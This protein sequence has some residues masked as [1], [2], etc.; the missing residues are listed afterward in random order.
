MGNNDENGPPSSV[1]SSSHGKKVYTDYS[2]IGIPG[3]GSCLFRSVV[4]GACLVS[5]K[6]SPSE[7]LEK[8]LADE[9]R[10]R[11]ADEFIQRREETE[12]LVALSVS[13]V[14]AFFVVVD[15]WA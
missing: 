11:V 6:P 10:A 8:Q 2:I 14:C 12:W 7:A 5:G 4:H 9:L 1:S 13:I 15:L 3:D